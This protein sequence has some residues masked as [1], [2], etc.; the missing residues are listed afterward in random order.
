MNKL[1]ESHL[2]ELLPKVGDRI[3]FQEALEVLAFLSTLCFVE[4]LVFFYLSVKNNIVESTD[5]C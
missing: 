3:S 2:K 5:S 4:F 1:T